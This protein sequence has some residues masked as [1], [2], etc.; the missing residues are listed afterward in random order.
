MILDDSNGASKPYVRL[1]VKEN[2][3]LITFKVELLHKNIHKR[4]PDATLTRCRIGLD[5]PTIYEFLENVPFNINTFSY[6]CD[7]YSPEIGY[8]YKLEWEK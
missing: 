4:V 1:R 6:D 2:T 3:Q 7:K 8:A 5:I